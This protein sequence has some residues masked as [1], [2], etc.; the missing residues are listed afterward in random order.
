MSDATPRTS[1]RLG[2]VVKKFTEYKKK[3]SGLALRQEKG[4]RY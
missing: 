1:A 4:C 2:R 3:V